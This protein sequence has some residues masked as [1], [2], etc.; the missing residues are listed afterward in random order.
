MADIRAVRLAKLVVN[1]CVEVKKNDWI[2]ISGDFGVSSELLHEIYRE[3][4]KAGGNPFL[5]PAGSDLQEIYYKEASEDQLQWISPLLELYEDKL[6]GMINVHGTTN[7]AAL[8]SIDPTKQQIR[9]KA[10]GKSIMPQLMKRQAEGKLKGLVTLFPCPALAQDAEMS[11]SEY[12]DFV[13]K[14]MFCDKEDPQAEWIKL[15]KKQQILVDWLNGREKVEIHGKHV[16]LTLSIKGR[17]FVSADG[18]SNMPD[19]EIYTG[20]VEDSAEGHVEFTYPAVE[21]G[22]V[23]EN[24]QLDFEKGKVVKAT[25][26]KNQEFLEAM[27]ATDDGASYLGELGI[28]TN[29]GIQRFTKQIL[30]DEKI[31]GTFHLAVGAGYPETGSKNKSGIH[32][33]MI[34]ALGKDGEIIVDD[35]PFFKNGNFVLWEKAGK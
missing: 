31:G 4:I 21:N 15:C 5:V 10:V 18:K 30:F 26:E 17:T 16:D 8:N 33:D 6:N 3:V 14:A 34:C 27:I 23:V 19:G 1:F 25:A 9:A 28:G 24:V 12:E 29:F 32:W 7:T 13:Y 20:P 22:R 2:S 35:E 11:L